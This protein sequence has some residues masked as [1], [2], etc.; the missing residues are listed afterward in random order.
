MKALI[1]TGGQGSRLYPLTRVT[2]KALLDIKGKAN[3]GSHI[4]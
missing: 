1:L 4:G 3:A 2:P